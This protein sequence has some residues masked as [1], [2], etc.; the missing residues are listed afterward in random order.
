MLVGSG[1]SVGTGVL[2]GSGVFVEV[3]S[4]VLVGNGVS[5]AGGS[6]G[7]TSAISFA[8]SDESGCAVVHEISELMIKIRQKTFIRWVIISPLG[9]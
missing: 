5:V 1:V 3:G 7:A 9:R 4:G 8:G 6:V 2:V